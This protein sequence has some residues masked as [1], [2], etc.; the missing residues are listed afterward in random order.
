[1]TGAQPRINGIPAAEFFNCDKRVESLTLADT[2][3]MGNFTA[4]AYSPA[5]IRVSTLADEVRIANNG[6]GHVHAVAA[7]AQTAV[8]LAGHAANSAFW[9]SDSDGKW[10]T[11]TYYKDVPQSIQNRNY[12]NPLASRL[13]TMSW[14][15]LLPLTAYSE[16][17][18]SG[19]F[20]GFRHSFAKTDP[21]RYRAFKQSALATA[22]VTD[23][24]LELL[25]SLRLGRRGELDML[26]IGLSAAPYGYADDEARL[27]L[28]DK[29]IRLDRDLERILSAI[30]RSVGLAN[31]VVM[32]TATGNFTP[33]K[34]PDAS[35]GIPTGEF[36]TDR[37]VSLLNMY[38]IAVYGNGNWVLGC[39]NRNFFLNRELIKQHNLDLTAV[40]TTATDFLRK[41]S[42]VMAA[43]SLDDIISNPVND[44]LKTLYDRTLPEFAG[45]ITVRVMP[46]WI[47]TEIG[48]DAQPHSTYVR[49]VSATMPAFILAPGLTPQRLTGKTD[50]RS[51][52]P[53]VSRL[54]RI[55]APNAAQCPAIL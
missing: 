29:Y 6:L 8:A 19:K 9:I 33:G 43:Y 48:R 14:T 39:H 38:L 7:D 52:A 46:G 30:D 28:H 1:M 18:T 22:E 53:S 42:G 4:E 40:R 55:P 36:R 16:V 23:V 41:M 17:P 27:Q 26:C 25:S 10:A 50:A 54:L 45:D 20:Y 15:P 44:D 24:A 31:A 11:S 49:A 13:D 5:A 34:A 2:R 21:L 51:L 12:R 3:F 47:V 35:F 37:A 32:V